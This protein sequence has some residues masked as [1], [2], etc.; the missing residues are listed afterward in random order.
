MNAFSSSRGSRAISCSFSQGYSCFSLL[1][2]EIS[3]DQLP[4][5]DLSD[6]FLPAAL[7]RSA[8]PIGFNSDLVVDGALEPLFAT[9]V[10][11]SGLNRNVPFVWGKLCC[12]QSLPLERVEL[13][14]Y[15]TRSEL[16]CLRY[17]LSDR[18]RGRNY[19]G[20]VFLRLGWK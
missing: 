6:P 14:L 17:F 19:P 8:D 16:F 12:L 5:G 20:S 18:F 1:L 4:R 15:D 2:G 11:F 13:Q 7:V 10:S 3:N 9:Q